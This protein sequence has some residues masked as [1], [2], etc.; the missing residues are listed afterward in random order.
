LGAL[1]TPATAAIQADFSCSPSCTVSE[2]T[3]VTF[4]S[5]STSSTSIEDYQWDLDGDGLFG[6]ADDPDE[7]N[8]RDA[9]TAQ[10]SFATAGNYTIGLRVTNRERQTSTVNKTVTVNPPPPPPSDE[11][12]LVPT[13]FQ[14]DRLR[15]RRSLGSRKLARLARQP[16]PPPEFGEDQGPS[17]ELGFPA[18]TLGCLELLCSIDA[19]STLD[20]T[21]PLIGKPF[22][23]PG[24]ID[25]Q[26]A[27]SRGY[28]VVGMRDTVWFYDK[29]GDPLLVP[30][31][32]GKPLPIP[33]KLSLCHLFRPLIP[34]INAALEG[35]LPADLDDIDGNAITVKNG[36]G[37]NCD[38]ATGGVKPANWSLDASD[39]DNYAFY[40][41]GKMFFDAR[42]L[43]D[44]YHK[45]FWIVALLLN[46]Q[47]KQRYACG[48][49]DNCPAAKQG[50]YNAGRALHGLV[51]IAVSETRD[52][53]D[54][55]T[56]YWAWGYPGQESCPNNECPYVGNI[57]YLS[58]GITSRHL[59]LEYKA[60]DGLK[61]G[62][63]QGEREKV[64]GDQLVAGEDRR[65]VTVFPADPAAGNLGQATPVFSNTDP[66]KDPYGNRLRQ[67]EPAV[68]HAPDFEDGAAAL[69]V[70][71]YGTDYLVLWLLSFE[72]GQPRAYQGFV[73]IRPSRN[74]TR[75]EPTP[76]K[77]GAPVVLAG[78]AQVPISKVVYRNGSLYVTFD[79]CVLWTFTFTGSTKCTRSAVRF[80]RI[81]IG[82]K[83]LAGPEIQ[84]TLLL[85]ANKQVDA[86]FGDPDL[87]W[88][89]FPVLEAN[90]SGDAAFV[91]QRAGAGVSDPEVRYTVYYEA[92]AG[93]R[94]SGLL[95]LAKGPVGG[96]HH[97]VGV[98][99]DP[100]DGTGIWMID[101]YG[102]KG[103]GWN[104]VVGK[105]LGSAQPNLAFE[106]AAAK[107]VGGASGTGRVYRL[108]LVLRNEGDGAGRASK[109][110][111]YLARAKRA[112]ASLAGKKRQV[113]LERIRL[114]RLRSGRARTIRLRVRVPARRRAFRY[115][116]IK[117][118]AGGRLRE[119]DERNNTAY[120]RLARR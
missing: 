85:T 72:A 45:R 114:P 94:P 37:I 70:T 43:W 111:I 48:C 51:A 62:D 19:V 78:S 116:A 64:E 77:T 71:K 89:L 5:T 55:W 47:A 31:P 88:Y 50:T 102:R 53:R 110:A 120:V 65:Q 24:N 58:A 27:A 76:Q 10:R 18:G 3:T 42:V 90:K 66:L 107:A 84:E 106:Q 21:P 100:W 29:A 113:L 92:E 33:Y 15:G 32:G 68:Q 80:L 74:L 97:Y 118:D 61:E 35:V 4:T 13:N 12:R 63:P 16:D 39:C 17:S 20:L 56:E 67:L 98:S 108:T 83:K 9:S 96:W 2:G 7:P 52:P 22:S 1:A 6:A 25:P 112:G 30:G 73:P 109:A 69:F 117:L 86:T 57:D 91:Y 36:Y 11:L 40:W 44:E 23:V 115:L 75:D 99:V 103:G 8:G 101:G 28:L 60:V 38:K 46:G 104:Y 95:K 14:S 82:I 49:P 105:V 87:G 79:E 81:G 41:P 59:L 26:I 34:N 93:P 119:Y 54:G